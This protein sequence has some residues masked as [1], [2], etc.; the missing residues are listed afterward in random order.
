MIKI[1]KECNKEFE[2]RTLER[3]L[4]N[5]CNKIG[6]KNPFYGKHHTEEHNKI[7]SSKLKGA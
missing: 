1:C 7:I 5:S 3:E 2:T 4:C 6:I